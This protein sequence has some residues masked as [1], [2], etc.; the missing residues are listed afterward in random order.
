VRACATALLCLGLVACA[1][2]PSPDERKDLA[3]AL[4]ARR[5]WQASTIR[6]GRFVLAAYSP[7]TPSRSSSLTIYIE[8]DGLAWLTRSRLSS[9]PTPRDPVGLRLALAHPDDQAAYLARPCQYVAAEATACDPR[10]WTLARFAP[11]V[12]H[13]MS[14]AIDALAQR[15]GARELTLVGYSGGGAVAALVAARRSDV[16]R[17]LTVAGNL[18][19]AAW[20]QHHGVSPLVESLNPVDEVAVLKSVPQWHA[21]GSDDANTTAALLRAYADRFPPEARPAIHIEPGFDHHCCWVDRWPKLLR[22][23]LLHTSP[24]R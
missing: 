5:G 12:I 14:Q 15:A 4:A 10:Y 11:E 3:D 16:V 8:G 6:A 9:D 19:H 7:A 18:D 23:A 22:N 24:A 17:L 2:V 13:A 21:V 1:S 20:T